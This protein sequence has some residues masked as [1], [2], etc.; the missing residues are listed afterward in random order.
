MKYEGGGWSCA[1][2]GPNGGWPVPGG[3]MGPHGVLGG[4][5]MA[6]WSIGLGP[7][8]MQSDIGAM[9]IEFSGKFEFWGAIAYVMLAGGGG[10]FIGE[11]IITGRNGWPSGTG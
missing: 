11:G 4:P 2:G 1:C 6:P 8:T 9:M 5:C 3:G 10:M 7:I